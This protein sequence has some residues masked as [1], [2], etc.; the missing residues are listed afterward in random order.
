M[1]AG[2]L[3]N[4][5][6]LP[7]TGFGF[8]ETLRM[9]D[10]FGLFHKVL[11]FGSLVSLLV[12]PLSCPGSQT[13]N[14]SGPAKPRRRAPVGSLWRRP[15]SD[16]NV[17]SETGLI[18]GQEGR[19]SGSPLVIMPLEGSAI[20]L[21]PPRTGKGA[22]IALNMLLPG[23]RGFTGSTVLIDPRGEIWVCHCASPSAT[24]APGS[25]D[26]SLRRC[27]AACRAVSGASS[28]GHGERFL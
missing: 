26:R 6:I 27:G 23:G 9:I 1:T 3:L 7:V 12:I 25:P 11:V 16:G 18:L 10:E 13:G 20:T 8:F 28:A 15:A 14:C 24:G 21:A 2:H 4:W 17:R 5:W 19:D 22:T